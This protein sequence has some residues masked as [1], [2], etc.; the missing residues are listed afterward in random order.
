MSLSNHFPPRQQVVEKGTTAIPIPI[1]SGIY[2]QRE[3][4][5]V[6]LKTTALAMLEWDLVFYRLTSNKKQ[7]SGWLAVHSG[8]EEEVT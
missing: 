4:E 8:Q 1:C 2:T 7:A 3:E 5:G 6:G